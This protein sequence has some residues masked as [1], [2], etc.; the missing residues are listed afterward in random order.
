MRSFGTG[1][2]SNWRRL[3]QWRRFSEFDIDTLV[4]QEFHD[5]SPM[6][7]P[8]PI[9]PHNGLRGGRWRWGSNGWFCFVEWPE[10]CTDTT[11]FLGSCPIALA[12]L[13]PCAETAMTNPGSINHAHTA[14]SFGAA[15]LGIE[16]KT[17]RTV[18]GAIWL[19]SEVF[20]GNTSHARD[21]PRWWLVGNLCLDCPAWS[22]DRLGLS[23][24]K[25]R[26][27]HGCGVQRMSQD[28]P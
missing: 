7:T 9:S 4:T 22:H 10:H 5:L 23:S 18:N 24:S 20:T 25:F 21:R 15:L 11:R 2:Q 14:V 16:R 27:A 1:E 28:I 3:S 19:G 8:W 12:F 17:G 26:R 13:T 6:K